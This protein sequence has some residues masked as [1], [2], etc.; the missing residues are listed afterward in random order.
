MHER[1]Q[2]LRLLHLAMQVEEAFE[3]LEKAIVRHIPPGGVRD[4]LKP[5]F[6]GGAAHERL[7]AEYARLNRELENA[8][9]AMR[10]EDLLQALLDCERIAQ[11]FYRSHL[12]DL[13]DPRL[14]DLF[15][16]LAEDEGHHAQ[17]VERAMKWNAGEF[18]T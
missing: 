5:L 12:D 18:G 10:P 14:V 8:S 16:K 6:E 3:G 17:A 15:K 9:A 11:N 4:S 13:S 2:D 1:L 7:K